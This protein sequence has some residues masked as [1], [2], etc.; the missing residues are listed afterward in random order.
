MKGGRQTADAVVIGAGFAGLS[1]AI[2]LARRGGGK[3]V[4]VEA[5]T[6]PGHHASGRNAAMARRVLA[7]PI[8]AALATRSLTRLRDLESRRGMDLLDPV[9]GLLIGAPEA[10][11]SLLESARGVPG[12]AD[13]VQAVEGADLVRLVPALRGATSRTGVYSP[14]CGVVDI[15]GLLTALLEEARTAGVRFEYETRVTGFEVV[16]G[17]VQGVET[18]RGTLACATVVN[19]AGHGAG[20]LGA[21]AGARPQPLDPSRR[22]L[23]VTGPT[24]RIAASAP[25]VWD[26]SCG[27][28]FRPEGEGLL[29]CACDERSWTHGPPRVD[30][31]HREVL[32]ETLVRHAPGLSGIRPTR[33]WVGLRSLTPD[34][35]FI[36]GRDPDLEGFV[37]AAGLGGHGMTTAMEVGELVADSILSSGTPSE[38][39]VAFDPGR[40]EAV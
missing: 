29:L 30:P 25:Y 10:C 21:L 5:E 37:W 32:A 20:P 38:R 33:A 26:V 11:L 39:S 1:T 36:L 24:A 40:W 23:Y 18:S 2:A 7:D 12:L 17:R 14:G 9:G 6:G 19:A 34:G 8:L 13:E 4:V 16:A 3:V 35:R 28:Y 15:H 22:H 31:D 27:F